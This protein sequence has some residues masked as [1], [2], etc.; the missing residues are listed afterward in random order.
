MNHCSNFN[1]FLVIFWIIFFIHYKATSQFFTVPPQPETES[2]LSELQQINTTEKVA[3]F[4]KEI[5][6]TTK[7]TSLII[8][9][10]YEHASSLHQQDQQWSK[11]IA[12]EQNALKVYEQLLGS[13]HQSVAYSHWQLGMLHEKTQEYYKASAHLKLA[14][15][16]FVKGKQKETA[17]ISHQLA[18]AFLMNNQQD[19]AIQTLNHTLGF[20]NPEK[21]ETE[22]V[23]QLL[24]LKG[25]ILATQ[26]K[27]EEAAQTFEDIISRYEAD[28]SSTFH[29]EQLIVAYQYYAW[30]CEALKQPKKAIAALQQA[31][32]I[33]K[34]RPDLKEQRILLLLDREEMQEG[35]HPKKLEEIKELM[36]GFSKERQGV[37]LHSLQLIEAGKIFKSGKVMEGITRFDQ[38]F[39]NYIPERV[40][41]ELPD[42]EQLKFAAPRD[43]L[44]HGYLGLTQLLKLQYHAKE[45]RTLARKAF[46]LC[47]L[48]DVL[49][50]QESRRFNRSIDPNM[51]GEIYRNGVAWAHLLD[52]PEEAW[53]FH[54]RLR[55]LNLLVQYPTFKII[56][57]TGIPDSLR[58]KKKRFERQLDSIQDFVL[59]LK[60]TEQYYA[61]GKQVDALNVLHQQQVQLEERLNEEY[62]RYQQFWKQFEPVDLEHTRD[63]LS[64]NNAELISYVVSDS[65]IWAMQIANWK[66]RLFKISN[67]P[68]IAENA[69][70][71][72]N[73]VIQESGDLNQIDSLGQLL[74]QSLF[75]PMGYGKNRIILLTDDWLRR[76][77]FEALVL[78]QKRNKPLSDRWL[79][80]EKQFSR[81]AIMG[82]LIT[83]KVHKDLR[84]VGEGI[85]A[86]APGQFQ[87]SGKPPLL[88]G[89]PVIRYL[90]DNYRADSLRGNQANS[91][92]FITAIQGKQA[93]HLTTHIQ[94][95]PPTI[96]FF[97]EEFPLDQLPIQ[98]P[99][100]A[101]WVASNL[102]WTGMSQQSTLAF[103]HLQL[104]G[105]QGVISPLWHNDMLTSNQLLQAFYRELLSGK[106][107]V[108][109]L[110]VAKQKMIKMGQQHPY[111]WATYNHY[112][113]SDKVRAAAYDGPTYIIAAF[114]LVILLL[115]TMKKG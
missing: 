15:Q 32:L 100:C 48:M 60:V 8:A 71:F 69:R 84:L 13:D 65:C 24:F 39:E 35:Y 21:I 43:R 66:K 3:Q 58:I 51:I 93:V 95:F 105:I 34:E 102:D 109:A 114:L 88:Q 54:E 29:E 64:D 91:K 78:P 96:H 82:V 89:E 22:H 14:Y 99:K 113:H 20:L 73:L 19:S 56:K 63:Y 11:A 108:A 107:Q 80:N 28:C 18:S 26:Y 47:Q 101:L 53:Y 42:P 115:W 45:S 90:L 110:Q 75:A 2:Y 17:P 23:G 76:F 36:A 61:L 77:P 57:Q 106:S 97:D 111:H 49:V 92:A 81:A 40:N 72:N 38:T 87:N 10:A 85:L 94:Q 83:E 67:Q 112:G 52:K 41:S 27:H 5:L 4:I 37:M 31:I 98:Q 86:V 68:A 6:D 12:A 55:T 16:F 1:K 33:N 50:H 70:L 44:V 7:D 9:Q 59:P 62:P 30:Q 103:E 25:E 104:K 79:L 46:K 74:Y